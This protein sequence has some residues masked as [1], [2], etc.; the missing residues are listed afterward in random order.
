MGGGSGV[1]VGMGVCVGD[2]VMVGAAVGICVGVGAVMRSCCPQAMSSSKHSR[3]GRVQGSSRMG[4]SYCRMGVVAM[5]FRKRAVDLQVRVYE[6][7]G[8]MLSWE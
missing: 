8:F 4:I 3:A 6:G 2:G 1:G 5:P 7:C